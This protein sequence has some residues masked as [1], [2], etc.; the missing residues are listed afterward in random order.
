MK[1]TTG[2]TTV[3]IALKN[4]KTSRAVLF[5]VLL[6]AYCAMP[7]LASYREYGINRVTFPQ[8]PKG[9]KDLVNSP[10]RY[11]GHSLNGCSENEPTQRPEGIRISH[12]RIY[13]RPVPKSRC[14][15]GRYSSGGGL[16]E[17]DQ[18]LRRKAPF[19][20][21]VNTTHPE[22]VCGSIS[23]SVARSRGN[24]DQRNGSIPPV[25]LRGQAGYNLRCGGGTDRRGSTGASPYRCDCDSS[26]CRR[27]N[28]WGQKLLFGSPHLR[29]SGSGVND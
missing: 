20:V 26:G 2:W 16:G 12:I 15:G 11:A 7:T 5:A 25:A 24:T 4:R 28:R 21:A 1:C 14:I 18:G 27:N 3:G 29:R 6:S 23:V 17:R 10:A 8:W 9:L 13:A 22:P 19:A